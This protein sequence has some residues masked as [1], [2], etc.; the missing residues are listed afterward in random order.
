MADTNVENLRVWAE[1]WRVGAGGVGALLNRNTGKSDMSL[2]DPEVIYEDASLPDH[3]GEIYHGHGGV[4]RATERWTE[5]FE[6]LTVEL[7]RIVGTGD[8]LVSI[9]RLRARARHTGIE[10]DEP[11]A[12]VWRFRAG[13]VVYFRSFRDPQ[14]ALQ[15]A[16]LA[17]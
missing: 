16:G 9:H 13:K 14:Q 5:P 6:E 15:A 2:L 8:R 7:E 12:Y 17:E 3:I 4:V 10:F 1:A 11:L